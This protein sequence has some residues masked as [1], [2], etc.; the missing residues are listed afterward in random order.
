M[1]AQ[2]KV[3]VDGW[4][5]VLWKPRFPEMKIELPFPNLLTNLSG[6]CQVERLL[7]QF[8]GSEE[9]KC[10]AEPYNQFFLR[11]LRSICK[12]FIKMMKREHSII[13]YRNYKHCRDFWKQCQRG[14]N[15]RSWPKG[16]DGNLLLYLLRIVP[17]DMANFRISKVKRNMLLGHHVKWF[18]KELAVIGPP[19][20]KT[21]F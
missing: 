19:T 4:V 17:S 12:C 9:N 2:N 8:V 1:I 16:N 21:Y 5:S 18:K 20:A 7:W 11:S 13:S 6:T 3:S 14:G 15:Q 10:F